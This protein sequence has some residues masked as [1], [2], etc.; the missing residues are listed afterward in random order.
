MMIRHFAGNPLSVKAKEQ[1]V[2][3]SALS[4][5]CSQIGEHRAR[6]SGERI[7]SNC[8]INGMVS[9]SQ[10]CGRFVSLSVRN[11]L[12]KLKSLCPSRRLH[13]APTEEAGETAS[14]TWDQGR[15][16]STEN[17][18]GAVGIF[19]STWQ[20]GSEDARQSWHDEGGPTALHWLLRTG[21][22]RGGGGKRARPLP[23]GSS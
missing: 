18:A 17:E 11:I 8:V 7:P 21:T 9:E 10:G 22:R 1:P 23:A 19:D 3:Q 4:G 20:D 15:A 16:L 13:V 14:S 5:Q 6:D 12:E 2:I